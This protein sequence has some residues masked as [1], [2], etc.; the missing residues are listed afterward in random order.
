MF[1][2]AHEIPLLEFSILEDNSLTW[3]QIIGTGILRNQRLFIRPGR[4]QFDAYDLENEHLMRRPNLGQVAFYGAYQVSKE[5]INH[6]ETVSVMVNLTIRF[7][8]M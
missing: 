8:R 4:A 7:P 6:H 5:M 3:T 2:I 1:V